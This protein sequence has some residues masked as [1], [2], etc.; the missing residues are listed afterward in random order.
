MRVAPAHL[1]LDVEAGLEHLADV[2]EVAAHA[3]QQRIGADEV[4]GALRQVA[5]DD[6]VVEGAGGLVLELAQQRV[7]ELGQLHELQAGRDAEQG[8]PRKAPRAMKAE[9]RPFMPAAATIHG[10]SAVRRSASRSHTPISTAQPPVAATTTPA[11][12]FLFSFSAR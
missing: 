2:V 8:N 9:R 3:H 11:T 4:G 12:R 1:V 6:A 10:M 5:D 7:V